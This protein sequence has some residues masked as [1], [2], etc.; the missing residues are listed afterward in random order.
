MIPFTHFSYL[1]QDQILPGSWSENMTVRMTKTVARKPWNNDRVK[2][3]LM[4]S[5]D[6]WKW[7]KEY[8]ILKLFVLLRIHHPATWIVFQRTTLDFGYK[9]MSKLVMAK[10]NITNISIIS[11]TTL[12]WHDIK[13]FC[14]LKLKWNI[15]FAFYREVLFKK[16][17]NNNTGVIENILKYKISFVWKIYSNRLNKMVISVFPEFLVREQNNE[18]QIT[19]LKTAFEY[20]GN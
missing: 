7:S 19:K 17:C 4:P 2:E 10:N 11:G 16:N 1:L 20:I 13:T 5:K 8:F 6:V 12:K 14:K 15:Q 18:N 9:I 3:R